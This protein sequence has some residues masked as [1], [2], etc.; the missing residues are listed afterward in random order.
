MILVHL[1]DEPTRLPPLRADPEAV[2]DGAAQLLA[3]SAQ[4]DDLGGFVAGPARVLDWQ[5]LGSQAYRDLL[6]PLGRLADAMSLG[7]RAVAHRVQVH[8]E[9]LAALEAERARLQ[10]DHDDLVSALAVVRGD[11]ARAAAEESAVLQA[12]ADRLAARIADYEHARSAW[13]A[14]LAAE[15]QAVVAALE[16]TMGLQ[17]VE[18]RYGGRPDPADE[19][20]A[21]RPDPGASPEVVHAWW[22]G[23]TRRQQVALAAAAPG[24]IGR[25]DGVAAWARH[26]A[27]TVALDR[28][29]AAWRSLREQGLLTPEERRALANAEAVEEAREAI[30]RGLDPVSGE[31]LPAQLYA[32][33]PYAFDG[34]GIVVLAVGDLDRA[35][36]VAVLVPGFGTDVGSA[37]VLAGR[38]ADVYEAART[39][40][41]RESSATVAWI[42]YDAPD[43]LLLPDGVGL[44]AVGVVTEGMA[45]RGGELLAD[46]IDGLR[47]GR[48]GA[49]AHLTVIGHSYGSTTL[50]HA[51]SE[52]RLGLDD[53]VFVGSPGVGGDVHQVTDLVIEPEHVWVGANSH[54][55]IA[56][57]GDRGSINLGA[58]G[59][60]GLGDDPAEDDF[61][62]RRFRAESITRGEGLNPLADHMG[63]F[64]HDTESL[65]NLAHVI[66]GDYDQ[67]VRASPV[68]DPWWRPPIDPESDREPG[69]ASTRKPS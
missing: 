45:E 32:Y 16:Q 24:V 3:A 5:G 67:V 17:D 10:D 29:L 38:A 22:R 36:N 12:R 26:A 30:G 33:D 65:A 69:V 41:P 9:R 18:R 50:G 43:N 14:A 20:L 64:A 11:V 19:A 57:L 34:D 8:A 40:G 25:L 44:D 1:P 35:D 55:L 39:L 53:L 68:T 48:D 59:G 56:D 61:G 31:A 37:A 15:E 62:A 4:L 49:P 51:A 13:S 28:D 21:G 47:A 2:A 58:L 6:R 66:T 63:Y 54:D 27:N 52:H 23:L 46:A 60:I 42:G 7:L